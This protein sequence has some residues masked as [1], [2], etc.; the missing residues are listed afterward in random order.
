MVA[1]VVVVAVV[2]VVV[3]VVVKVVLDAATLHDA[4]NTK[5]VQATSDFIM[6]T[7]GGISRSGR[8]NNVNR[9]TRQNVLLILVRL[10]TLAPIS[11]CCAG[12]WPC[13][14]FFRADGARETA[15]ICDDGSW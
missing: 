8:R 9:E 4:T 2:E 12:N 10:I 3:D 13:G 11:C 6:T 14:I 1:V 15:A 5:K 7:G